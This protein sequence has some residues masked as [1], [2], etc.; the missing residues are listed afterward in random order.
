MLCLVACLVFL[1]FS[2][3]GIIHHFVGHDLEIHLQL[4]CIE[5]APG[6]SRAELQRSDALL[7]SV[8]CGRASG[9]SRFGPLRVKL[10]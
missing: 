10:P 3:N 2:I 9:A 1:E 7:C 6:Y 8:T 5:C 4:V